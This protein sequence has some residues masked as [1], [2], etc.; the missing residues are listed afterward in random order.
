MVLIGIHTKGD[1][2]KMKKFVK[3]KG[4][5]Y[6]ICMDTEG[7]TVKEYGVDSYPDYYVIDKKG[8]LRV[9]D[10][11]NSDLERTIKILL[12]EGA[13]KEEE[14]KKEESK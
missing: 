6:P 5:D 1:V 13:D 7:K 4:L 11:A 8:N 12:K 10:L 9:A 2:A 3:D 14:K